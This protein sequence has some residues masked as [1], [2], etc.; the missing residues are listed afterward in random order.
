MPKVIGLTGGIATGKSRVSELL[1]ELG[2]AVE[3]SDKIVHEL[4]APGGAALQEIAKKFGPQYLTADGAL[5]RA[6]LG[7]LVFSDA[8]ARAKLGTIM[9]VRVYAELHERMKAHLAAGAD[10]VVLDIP[11]LVEGKLAGNRAGALI[12][13]DLVVLVYAD[14]ETQVE[15]LMERDDYDHDEAMARIRSQM[16]IHKKREHADV[17]IDNSG[18]WDGV[19]KKVEALYRDWVAAS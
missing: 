14:P 16:P 13:F 15:R 10:V 19:E 6:K 17:I 8:E 2:A 4:Q 9:H 18:K 1:R 11:L 7:Q 3:C 5:D 12:P